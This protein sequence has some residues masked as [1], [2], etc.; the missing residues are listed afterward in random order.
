M[1]P[2]TFSTVKLKVTFP[3]YISLQ[4]RTSSEFQREKLSDVSEHRN[5]PLDDA[6]NLIVKIFEAY[7]KGEKYAIVPPFG[8]VPVT[9][10][11]IPL[12]DKHPEAIQNLLNI[13]VENRPLTTFQYDK[14]I[15]YLQDRKNEIVKGDSKGGKSRFI[16]VLCTYCLSSLVDSQI[17]LEYECCDFI[18]CILTQVQIR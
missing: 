16:L 3:Y 13:L 9:P 10:A 8:A 4:H 6:L 17:I 14:I 1:S 7:S 12:G 2:S 18:G 15:G 5:M 11:G